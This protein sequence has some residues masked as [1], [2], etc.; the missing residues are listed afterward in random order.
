MF[1]TITVRS[2]MD[3]DDDSFIDHYVVSSIRSQNIICDTLD[4]VN[5]AIRQFY[6]DS[7]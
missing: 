7:E 3:E 5:E 1:N 2:V 6:D 4:E